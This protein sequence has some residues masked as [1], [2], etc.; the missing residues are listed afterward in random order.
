MLKIIEHINASD[1]MG[2][3]ENARDGLDHKS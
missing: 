3:A 2:K 1:E